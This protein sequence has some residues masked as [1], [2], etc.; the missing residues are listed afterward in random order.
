MPSTGSTLLDA[1]GK[2]Y[3]AG[4]P[5]VGGVGEG[6]DENQ[7]P[8]TTRSGWFVFDVPESVT[9][10][11]TLNVQSNPHPDTTRPAD[12]GADRVTR[13]LSVGHVLPRRSPPARSTAPCT[14]PA[15]CRCC[16]RS[17]QEAQ[18]L[19]E[20]LGRK[21]IDHLW[22]DHDLGDEDTIRPVVDLMVQLAEH[23]VPLDVG[24]VHIQ[25]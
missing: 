22:L 5:Y 14:A 7:L 3:A 4:G 11:K 23:G 13:V 24:Q 15:M 8:G 10:L 21:R 9:L 12:P 6:S 2:K 25:L 17:S 1:A 18:R 19:L 20:G 16:P